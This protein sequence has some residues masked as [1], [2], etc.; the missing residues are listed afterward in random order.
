MARGL[1]TTA[2]AITRSGAIG[3]AG[4]FVFVGITYLV[5][6]RLVVLAVAYLFGG[7]LGVA[8][9]V[10]GLVALELEPPGVVA[11]AA[12]AAL[13][14]A[15]LATV[16]EERPSDQVGIS[17]ATDRPIAAGLAEAAAILAFIAIGVAAR[18]ERAQWPRRAV[19]TR[20][21]DLGI[22]RDR[23]AT[24]MALIVVGGLAWA[25]RMAAAP[26]GMPPG[27]STVVDS[28]RGGEGFASALH[29]P[30]A[31]VL[32]AFAPV[33]P[34]MLT[35]LV[36]SATVA[37]VVV[38]GWRLGG[39]A[40]AVVAGGLAA[41]L[42]SI[43]GQQMPEALA[44]LGVI[45]GLAWAWPSRLT[46]GRAVLAGLSVA[47][48]TLA[49]PEALLAVPVVVAWIFVD[50]PPSERNRAGTRRRAPL[51]ALLVA[52]FLISYAPWGRW[53]DSEHGTRLPSTNLGVTL[54]GAN[55][56]STQRGSAIG[57][58]DVGGVTDQPVSP[59]LGENARD[60]AYRSLAWERADKNRALAIGAARV[61]RG[62]EV[63]SPDNA[64][65]VRALRGLPLPGRTVGAVGEMVVSI[66]ALVTLIA[67]RRDWRI[68]LPFMAL[69]LLFTVE[70]ALLFGDRGLRAW[71]APAVV[72]LVALPLSLASAGDNRTTAVDEAEVRP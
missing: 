71:V 18:S 54:A 23:L 56:A 10:A 4:R 17:F 37:V 28:L 31:P 33:S 40:T 36:T 68:L 35:M 29:P 57:A 9:A 5:G 1:R 38:L 32:A 15:G 47:A 50:R 69:P 12:V 19:S 53:I 61:L 66:L 67:R 52:G 24:L 62:W 60:E 49:R 44:A 30:L 16:L 20:W 46:K 6:G 39:R 48:A 11:R 8:V 51:A 65:T 72:L 21:S 55:T 13:V 41:V 34:R 70:S 26:A 3:V 58:W 27:Y 14:A 43:W 63:W 2:H 45:A 42:P 7:L 64:R 22:T 59:S 25:V